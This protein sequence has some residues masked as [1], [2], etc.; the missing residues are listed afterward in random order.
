MNVGAV[1]GQVDRLGPDRDSAAASRRLTA[2]RFGGGTGGASSYARCRGCPPP[3]APAAAYRSGSSR[4]FKPFEEPTMGKY[5]VAW[6]LGVPALVLV[7][8]YFFMH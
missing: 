8:I 4:P 7:A 2:R 6:I 3:Q 1:R 5:V